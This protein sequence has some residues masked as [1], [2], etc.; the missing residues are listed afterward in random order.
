MGAHDVQC[1]GSSQPKHRA[2][3]SSTSRTLRFAFRPGDPTLRIM[4]C[5]RTGSRRFHASAVARRADRRW[6]TLA[7]PYAAWTLLIALLVWVPEV[8]SGTGIHHPIPATL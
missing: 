1:G 7:I 8:V 4:T 2:G 6:T 5:V 3:P